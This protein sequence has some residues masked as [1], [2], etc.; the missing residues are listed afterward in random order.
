MQF[1]FCSI[2]LVFSNSVLYVSLK[3]GLLS[4]TALA[5]KVESTMF[6]AGQR[7]RIYTDSLFLLIGKILLSLLPGAIRLAKVLQWIGKHL[8]CFLSPVNYLVIIF[9]LQ[10]NDAISLQFLVGV[11]G[12]GPWECTLEPI[13][14]HSNEQEAGHKVK[15]TANLLAKRRQKQLLLLGGKS[16]EVIRVRCFTL[17]L[18]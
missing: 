18:H 10:R 5:S 16:P 11:P 12:E 7:T 17:C 13:E 14:M 3:L 6:A 2:S 9:V 8:S 4:I 15:G 1:R